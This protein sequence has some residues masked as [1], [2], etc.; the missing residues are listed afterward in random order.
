[1]IDMNE[2]R[3]KRELYK[4]PNGDSIEATSYQE[5]LK[6]YKKK[7]TL[8]HIEDEPNRFHSR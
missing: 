7:R 3:Q 4:M 8:N 6:I 1:M 2:R 5:A